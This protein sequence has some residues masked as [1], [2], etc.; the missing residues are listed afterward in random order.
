MTDSP[1]THLLA[2]QVGGHAGVMTSEDG[3]LLIKPALHR[4]LEFYQALQQDPSFATLRAF[5]PKFLG[6]L[7]LEGQVDPTQAASTEGIVV[8]PIEAAKAEKDTWI[9]QSYL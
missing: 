4:E 3:S 8:Q 6:V 2:S 5:A 7:K 9:L 1:S